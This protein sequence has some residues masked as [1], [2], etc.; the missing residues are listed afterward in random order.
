MRI[1]GEFSQSVEFMFHPYSFADFGL[2]VPFAKMVR[3]ALVVSLVI[4]RICEKLECSVLI[5]SDVPG[6]AF[7]LFQCNGIFC[8][9]AID[10]AD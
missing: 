1:L 3:L 8:G 7:R 5:F 10:M 9:V 6:F 2:L 4:V